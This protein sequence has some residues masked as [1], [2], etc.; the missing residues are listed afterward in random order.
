MV[1][2]QRLENTVGLIPHSSRSSWLSIAWDYLAH[3]Y[4]LTMARMHDRLASAR[5]KLAGY[6]TGGSLALAGIG[7]GVA[8][9]SSGKE[10]YDANKPDAEQTTPSYGAAPFQD[11]APVSS[12]TPDAGNNDTYVPPKEDVSAPPIDTGYDAGK[13]GATDKPDVLVPKDEGSGSDLEQ[14]VCLDGD[15]DG[16]A[17]TG[18]PFDLR[19]DCKYVEEDDCD[20]DDYFVN[21]GMTEQK[22]N[23]KDDD[24]NPKTKDTYTLQVEVLHGLGTGPVKGVAFLVKNAADQKATGVKCTT[25]DVDG[26]ATC[27]F[28][29]ITGEHSLETITTNIG[30]DFYITQ[31]F[32]PEVQTALEGEV[33]MTMWLVEKHGSNFLEYF[34]DATG[35]SPTIILDG[36]EQ[37]NENKS[38]RYPAQSMKI[39]V[40]QNYVVDGI[41]Y[42]PAM[43][44]GVQD[45][46]DSLKQHNTTSGLIQ[47]VKKESEANVVVVPYDKNSKTSTTQLENGGIT[48]ATIYFG[49]GTFSDGV[50]QIMS[51]IAHE[52]THVV[53]MYHVKGEKYPGD[54]A[55]KSGGDGKVTPYA[56]CTALYLQNIGPSGQDASHIVK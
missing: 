12:G 5:Y 3:D 20:D 19:K 37:P 42:T 14:L 7:C 39:F 41:N 8:G 15:G 35:T 52:I 11:T 16:R 56:A 43:E 4:H 23:G 34:Q 50:D 31:R 28:P 36:V 55:T 38:Y 24:C 22:G 40:P 44:A 47:L 45:W 33:V 49:K 9:G 32:A 6:A 30:K 53:G 25:T 13:D 26:N 17:P 27:E 46:I 21:P 10:D 18:T 1:G 54:I 29:Q 2:V 51:T 48:G